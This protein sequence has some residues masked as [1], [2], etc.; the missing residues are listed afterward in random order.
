[1][2]E[3]R[4]R[5]TDTTI[6]IRNA[7]LDAFQSFVFD[8]DV[9]EIGSEQTWYHDPGLTVLFDPEHS[10]TCFTEMLENAGSL[11]SRFD[12]AQVEQGCW[13]M[14]GAGSD[15]NLNELIWHDDV[16]IQAKETLI[17]SMYDVYRDLFSHDP[18][19]EACEMWW[20]GLAYDIH[21][22]GVADVVH[23]PEHRRIQ[24]AMFKTLAKILKLNSIDCQSAALHG[25]NHVAHPDT[26]RLIESFIKDHPELSDESIEY[27]RL[28]A[29]GQAL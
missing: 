8:H 22:M 15:G 14:F 23:N 25:L 7:S 19:G 20:D 28:C 9:H 21:P 3:R 24:D 10:A 26:E 12:R 18:L 29:K 1:M 2:S 6:D 5:V 11:L 4:P 27:A 17:E 13:A 16:S